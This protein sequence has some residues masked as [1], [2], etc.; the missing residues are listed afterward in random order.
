MPA[1]KS[2]KKKAPQT[3]RVQTVP[4]Q[5][6]ELSVVVGVALKAM[7]GKK[8]TPK[9]IEECQPA[10]DAVKKRAEIYSRVYR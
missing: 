7:E 6:E 1:S 8:M 5:A 4:V 2:I 3:K 10:I 9:Q